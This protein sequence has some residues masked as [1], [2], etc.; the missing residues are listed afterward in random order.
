MT[1]NVREE[2]KS[3]QACRQHPLP[4]YFIVV[5]LDLETFEMLREEIAWWNWLVLVL[6]MH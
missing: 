3:L 1:D 2:D 4:F 6:F 5:V